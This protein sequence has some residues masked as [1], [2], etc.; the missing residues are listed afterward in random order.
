MCPDC[1]RETQPSTMKRAGRSVRAS[2][3]RFAADGTPIVTYSLMI[4][5]LLVFVAQTLSNWFGTNEVTQALWYAPAYSLPDE[6]QIYSDA[7]FQPWRM[8]TAMFT[9]ST[10]TVFHILFNLFALWLFGRNLEALLGRAAFLTLYLFAGLGGSL[11]VM[12]WL[13]ADPTSVGTPTVGAS[14]AIFGVLA[15]TLL[16]SR[17][18]NVSILP[19]AVL[20]GINLAIGFMPGMS[21]SWQAHLG[22]LS[23]GAATMGILLATRG[24]RKNGARVVAL[25]GLGLAMVALSAAYWVVLPSLPWMA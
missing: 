6:V 15:A 24:P 5:C 14:G 4:A 11:A 12:F 19:L 2:S 3:R 13:Y 22:G 8:V 18:A 16:A 25:V 7:S 20:L 1:V 10:G 23:M 17:A 9:H 21:I